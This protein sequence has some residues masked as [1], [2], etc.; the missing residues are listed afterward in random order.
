[1]RAFVRSKVVGVCFC[2]LTV[3]PAVVAHAAAGALDPSFSGNGKVTLQQGVEDVAVQADGKIVAV[4]EYFGDFSLTRFDPDGTRDS[5][6]GNHGVVHT[7]FR[8]GKGCFAVATSVL[9]Q[10]ADQQIVVVGYSYC[11]NG[12]FAVARYNTDGTLDPTFGHGGKVMTRFTA[13]GH[14]CSATP[15]AAALQSDGKI[16]AAGRIGK[17]C[18]WKF[19]VA[20]YDMGGSLDTTFSGDGR[21]AT[22]IT[23][24]VDQAEGI[25]VQ[26]DGSIVVAGTAALGRDESY[27]ERMAVVR[28][29]PHGRLD[30]SFGKGGKATANFQGESTCHPA[31][32]HAVALQPNGRIVVAGVAG[33][34]FPEMALARFTAAG[35]I[36]ASFGGNGKVV[37]ELTKNDCE[38]EAFAVA[39][40]PDRRIVA[41]GAAGCRS[42]AFGLARYL[43]HGALDR[44]FGNAGVVTTLFPS[45]QDYEWVSGIA[46]QQDGK[47][48]AGGNALTGRLVRYLG[49]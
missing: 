13:G 9:V 2:I 27:D 36:D 35:H 44:T 19:A 15:A 42:P 30:P 6:F 4:G 5:K 28:Y 43:P 16:L 24:F 3:A 39:V 26:S 17:T 29:L 31:E 38:S 21:V 12:W 7:P 11:A 32:G 25:A 10:P 18:P 33:C 48:V 46:L 45:Q 22:D 40:L 8:T 20:R 47:I 37:T 14:T 49:A 1:M 34:G 41:G 23:P